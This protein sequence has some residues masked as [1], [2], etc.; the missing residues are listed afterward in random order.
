[1]SNGR[2][3]RANRRYPSARRR[4]ARY[5]GA[6]IARRPVGL[7]PH[8]MPGVT[9]R[10]KLNSTR[11]AGVL[12]AFGALSLLVLVIGAI[13]VVSSTA[14][15]ITGTVYAY[16][17]VNKDLPNAAEVAVDTFETTK[18]LDRNGVPLQQVD[19]QEGGW[20]TFVALD[21]VSQYAIDAT[22]ASEDATFWSHYGVEPI[23]LIRL[24]VI[25]LSGSGTSGGSTIT[26]QLARGLYPEQIG[27]ELS[28]TRKFKEAL[29]AIALDD[30]FS[31]EDIL[32]MYLN[33]IFYGQRSYGIEA[34]ANT[35]FN[36]HADELTL[37]E[38]SLLAGLPQ[39]PS[40]FDPTV[41]FDQA[42]IRQQYVLNQ[43]VK[44]GYITEAEAKAAFE[45][46]LDPQTRNGAVL[47]APHFTQYVRTYI[48][49]R[50]PGALYNGGLT[51]TT[52]LDVEL[53]EEAERLVANG[54]A[55]ISGYN[56]NNGSMVA[57]VPWNGQI[58]VMVGSASFDD[59][60][61]GGQVNYAIEKRQ[62]GSSMKP[63]VYAAAFESGWNP[64][65]MVMDGTLQ[66]PTGDPANP[67]YSPNNYSG[68]FY[69]AVS[70]RTA[71]A[72][73]FNIPAVKAIKYAGI[74]H[75]MDLAKRMGMEESLDRPYYDYGL[76]LS[77][78]S[79]EVQLLEHTNV[80]ATF[81]NNGKYVAA[82]P[83]MKIVD[84]QGNVLYD[85]ERDKPWE[86]AP[87]GLRAEYA[88]QITSILTDNQS[89][90]LIFTEN[91]LF[92]NTQEALGRPTA[93]KSGT[94]DN[95]RDIWTMGYT[96]DLAVGVWV[97]N[98]SSDGSSPPELPE[99]DGIAGAGPI[100]QDMMFLMHQDSRWSGYLDG[101]NGRPL[102]ENFPVPS[103]IYEGEVCAA[104]G[105][106]PVA[107]FETRTE[108]LVRGGGPSLRCDQI[109]AYD[110]EELQKEQ[111]D[112][113]ENG[114]KYVGAAYDR[115]AMYA[116]AVRGFNSGGSSFDSSP[117]IVD[118]NDDGSSNEIT[119][120]DTTTNDQVPTE[121]S[122][123]PP[124]IST[125][126]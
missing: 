20:R 124:I 19:Q 15:A 94:T 112:M 2:I 84:S 85:V 44:L 91:N 29:A 13:G 28:P 36:K 107:G 14:A 106:K 45:E 73:S 7:P 32:T 35:Y 101:P 56:R 41:R 89:R 60:F 5:Q 21:Q 103:G 75:V 26:Q 96:T 109:S 67:Y 42:K 51:I 93:A 78:G 118:I 47:H 90:A 8:L 66:E 24:A 54:V 16:R 97:G 120:P 48:E 52:S 46:N 99:L 115:V 68:N 10:K 3:S 102:S 18:I 61:I 74:E 87:Q 58:L 39:A 23:A 17:E 30:E 76:S 79:G 83:I 81:A 57:M 65:T 49:D 53:Q 64:A 63:V 125:D 121:T 117:Q 100:W 72:N 113:R 116:D 126:D 69:G 119:N 37:G 88:Y 82:N 80:Y 95:W 34:A 12:I 25:N 71:L 4:R 31:K 92:G 38:A 70:V 77:L 27:T 1:M 62:P 122:N 104:T 98:T 50:W 105:G 55:E 110:A 9:R 33:Q 6:L 123:S 40:F 11:T 43:M 108:V 22:V 114:G 86:A 59:P 111:D